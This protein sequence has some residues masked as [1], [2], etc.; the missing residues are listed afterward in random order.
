VVQI[1]WDTGKSCSLLT[2]ENRGLPWKEE[3]LEM[4]LLVH[5]TLQFPLSS[6]KTGEGFTGLSSPVYLL[7]GQ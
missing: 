3:F 6:P 5:Q 4:G 7:R 2:S 1:E